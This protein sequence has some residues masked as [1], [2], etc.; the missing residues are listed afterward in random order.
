MNL[1]HF[2]SP[3]SSC[4]ALC[5]S[6]LLNAILASRNKQNKLKALLNNLDDTSSTEDVLECLAA[7][8]QLCSEERRTLAEEM[9]PTIKPIRER[10]LT[11]GAVPLRP[12]RPP[13]PSTSSKKASRNGKSKGKARGGVSISGDGKSSAGQAGE[14]QGEEDAAEEFYSRGRRGE[15]NRKTTRSLPELSQVVTHNLVVLLS[16]LYG[17]EVVGVGVGASGVLGVDGELAD[18]VDATGVTVTRATK[19]AASADCNDS[20]P[21]SVEENSGDEDDQREEHQDGDDARCDS[22]GDKNNVSSNK[23]STLGGSTGGG[24][25]A[26][27]P[28]VLGKEV[29]EETRISREQLADEQ[30]LLFGLAEP[31]LDACLKVAARR[32]SPRLF[33]TV[34]EAKAMLRRRLWSSGDEPAV[35]K[36]QEREA[37]VDLDAA[38]PRV[39][40]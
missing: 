12:P 33:G 10:L 11:R 17:E 7:C 28:A 4:S 32:A 13:P 5:L 26:R 34:V 6:Y 37:D 36:K 27:F 2:I 14:S 9:E 25:G 40:V 20:S 3:F 8:P 30:E 18:A 38:V 35:L 23:H 1:L 24:A 19:E 16:A 31:L 15:G 29:E 39:K 22:D 21:A